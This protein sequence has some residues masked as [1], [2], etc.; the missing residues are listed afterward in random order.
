MVFECHYKNNT[1]QQI[2]SNLKWEREYRLKE[3]K[4]RTTLLCTYPVENIIPK[5]SDSTGAYA[6]W[7]SDL[8]TMYDGVIFVRRFWKGLAFN[9]D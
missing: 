9:L 3:L 2:N 1:K 6:K 8:L 5:L 7:M 4:N